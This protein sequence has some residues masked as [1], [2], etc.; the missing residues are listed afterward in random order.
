MTK[1][2]TIPFKLLGKYFIS[3]CKYN[4]MSIKHNLQ[5]TE[6][7]YTLHNKQKKLDTKWEITFP[8]LNIIFT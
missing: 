2:Y 1:I 3:Q 4:K 6:Y 8:S 5:L 7:V